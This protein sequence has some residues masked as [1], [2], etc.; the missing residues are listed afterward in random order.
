MGR[1]TPGPWRWAHNSA[2]SEKI[3]CIDVSADR[4]EEYGESVAYCQG[5]PDTTNANAA[6]IAT[7][8]DLLEA[9]RRLLMHRRTATDAAFEQDK[10]F[11]LTAIAK[12]EGIQ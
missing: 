3:A 5:R 10:A 8:P 2:S 6:L 4:G 12:A 7:A 1:H 9:L 11:A